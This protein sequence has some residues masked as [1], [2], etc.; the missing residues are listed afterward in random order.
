AMM[1]TLRCD[2]PDIEEFVDAKR[3]PTALRNFNVSVQVTDELMKAVEADADWPL[4]FPVDE[5]DAVGETKR[6]RWPGRDGEVACRIARRIRAR[7]LWRRVMDAAYDSAEPGVLFVDRI[8][9]VN[10]L[11]Y[12]EH[13]TSTN[14][15]G[16][17]PLPAY[18]ACDLGSI[19]L[20]VFVREPFT[21]SAALDYDAIERIVP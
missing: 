3:D 12:R 16:E 1:G 4:C 19:N 2:H 10:N 15:C 6:L 11:Y 9:A 20:A 14:P 21:R 13:I 18:G 8:N 5:Q 7:D 17:I